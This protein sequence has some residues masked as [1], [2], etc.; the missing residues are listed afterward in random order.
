MSR[1]NSLVA[2]F[3]ET[4]LVSDNWNQMFLKSL[5]KGLTLRQADVP[6]SN[7]L[8]VGCGSGLWLIEAAKQWPVR[9]QLRP[10]IPHL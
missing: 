7:V 8:D 4:R 9:P 10:R 5:L 1:H 3:A 6:P 2:Y